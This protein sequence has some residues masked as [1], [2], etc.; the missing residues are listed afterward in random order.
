MRRS[1]APRSATVRRAHSG[2]AAAA[3]AMAASASA[4]LE[5]AT[6]L[7]SSPLAGMRFSK[8]SPPAAMRSSP[9][10]TLGTSTAVRVGFMR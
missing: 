9:A 10:M 6:M 5:R 2:W 7:R 3:A 1:S 8:V 4:R